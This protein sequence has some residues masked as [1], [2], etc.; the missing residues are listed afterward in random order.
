MPAPSSAITALL[1]LYPLI[2]TMGI[3]QAGAVSEEAESPFEVVGGQAFSAAVPRDFY[4]EGN[5]IPTEKR[6]AA[7]IRTAA[8]HRI[9][10]ALLDTSG[11]S[12]QVQQK[13]IGMLI[14][15]SRIC[16]G[17]LELQVGSYGFGLD[18]GLSPPNTDGRIRFYNQAGEKVAEGPAKRD[19]HVR[20]LKPLQ[21]VLSEGQPRLYLGRYQLELGQR[22]Q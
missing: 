8:G 2:W 14:T 4:L 1:L 16:V 17:R 15:E 22:C 18:V 5:A 13:Y 3:R 6:N 9:L 12:S 10:F 11:Y 21:V 7:L 19:S 20:P